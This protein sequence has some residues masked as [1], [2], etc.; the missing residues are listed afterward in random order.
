MA[1]FE[2]ALKDEDDEF[3]ASG[4]T[5]G[6]GDD[7]H[8]GGTLFCWKSA[9]AGGAD[10]RMRFTRFLYLLAV[11][12]A[13]LACGRPAA[14]GC[15]R[16]LRAGAEGK[17]PWL[18]SDRDY[19]YKELLNRVFQNLRQFNPDLVGEKKKYTMT[20]P[21][22]HREPKKTIFANL[23]DIC[24][25][26]HRQPEHLIQFLFAELGTTGST[27]GE[28]RLVIK[29]RFTP[30]QI[31][32]I[33]RRYISAVGAQISVLFLFVRSVDYVQCKT[34]KSPDT[35]LVK[36]NRL[37]FLQCESCN[38]TRSVAAIKS[39]FKALTEKRAVQ[40]RAAAG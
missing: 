11:V 18:G 27:D 28:Q 24:R 23:V 2:E 20:P 38:S 9:R 40:R 16:L 37:F 3:G 10:A 6:E 21:S 8:E 32:A 31:E 14:S 5:F 12:L 4:I 19:L 36:E 30:K 34:C 1:E 39:G 7:D 15:W 26:M 13:Y 25:K 17:E 33:I 22:I 29:G 35:I